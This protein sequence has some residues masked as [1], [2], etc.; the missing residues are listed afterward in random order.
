[1]GFAEPIGY[2]S[3]HAGLADCLRGKPVTDDRGQALLARVAD[4]L[5]LPKL[6]KLSSN[7]SIDNQ[8]GTG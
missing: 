1:L 5:S 6:R 3:D 2:D 4:Y 8:F 7:R